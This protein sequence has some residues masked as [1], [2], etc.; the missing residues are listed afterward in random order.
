MIELGTILGLLGPLAKNWTQPEVVPLDPISD[1]E[2]EPAYQERKATGARFRWV[3]EGKLRAREREGW[4]PF[5]DR[6]GLQR[7]TVYVDRKR[8]LLLMVKD[9]GST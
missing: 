9:S 6:D 4:K 5:Y 2:N 7:P 3:I 1:I 8:E